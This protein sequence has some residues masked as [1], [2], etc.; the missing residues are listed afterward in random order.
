MVIHMPALGRM[1]SKCLAGQAVLA[2]VACDS[3]RHSARRPVR[4][5][6]VDR[7]QAL[8]VPALV[9]IRF[10]TDTKPK[11]QLPAAAEKPP[12]VAVKAVMQRLIIHADDLLRGHRT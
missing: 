5:S 6:R 9:A 4:G 7:P 2:P 11:Y 12:K 8:Y 1:G 10:R 3:L